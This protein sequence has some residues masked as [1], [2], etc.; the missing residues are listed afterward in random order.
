MKPMSTAL[1]QYDFDSDV[2][3]GRALRVGVIMKT[4]V[5]A[6]VGVVVLVILAVVAPAFPGANKRKSDAEPTTVK[7]DI[8]LPSMA[9]LAETQQMQSK[10][11][12]KLTVAPVSFSP[13]E[14]STSSYRRV[15][16]GFKE[17]MFLP[18]QQNDVFVER[19][20]KPVLRVDP[21]RLRFQVHISNQMPR[22]FHGSG[23]AVQ[24]SVSGKTMAI[25]PAGYGDFVNT[26]I[27][28]RGEQDIEIVG[29]EIATI[30]DPTTVGLFF[31]DVV[32]N[33][34]VAGNVTEKQNFEWYFSYRCQQIEKE[35]EVP[36]PD[37]TWVHALPH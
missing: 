24:F 25:D 19:T 36:A 35:L 6:A 10:G 3:C 33:T 32:T 15:S 28:P 23:I 13:K 31:F 27:P 37:R 5:F 26:I 1:E 4:H 12:L 34:D 21:D 2:V 16:P 18:H 22:V 9:P 29:P 14:D 11:G 17:T 30:Q 20:S 7:V 8:K